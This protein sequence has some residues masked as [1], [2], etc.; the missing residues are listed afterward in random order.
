MNR[1]ALTGVE[2]LKSSLTPVEMED[3][4][5]ELQVGNDAALERWPPARSY[6]QATLLGALEV[7]TLTCTCRRDVCRRISRW[8]Q[9]GLSSTRVL[10]VRRS[11][12]S[13]QAVCRCC[14]RP[15]PTA[16]WLQPAPSA[17]RLTR[18]KASIQRTRLAVS[19]LSSHCVPRRFEQR[20]GGSSQPWGLEITLASALC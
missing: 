5:H 7:L 4:L 8:R 1:K 18:R 12:S 15:M 16:A 17:T 11:T 3:V 9:I 20:R 10:L 6:P 19:I 13:S 2:L 14:V